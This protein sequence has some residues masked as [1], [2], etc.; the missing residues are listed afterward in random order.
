MRL[1]KVIGRVTLSQMIPAFEGGRWLVVNPY[2]RDQF[3]NGDTPPE[4]LSD[5]PSLVV[6]D[7]LGGDVGQTIGFIEG[8]EAASPF[9]EPT[10]VDAIN[11]ALVDT[12]YHSPKK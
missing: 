8:R 11:A 1:G 7:A 12:V 10:P 5:E 4:G 6:F 3:Q 9:S 2:T